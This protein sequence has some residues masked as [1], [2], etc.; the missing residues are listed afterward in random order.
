[1]ETVSVI[2]KSINIPKGA[3]PQTVEIDAEHELRFEAD[4]DQTVII[5]MV[6]GTGEFFGA[7]LAVDRE[8]I[9]SGSKGAIFTWHGCTLEIYGN[10]HFYIA[11]ET[12]MIPYLNLAEAIEDERTRAISS[13]SQGPRVVL[14]GPTDSG[15]SS[16]SRLLMNY[17]SRKG[18]FP[19]F[20][21]LDIGQ[22]SITI[23]AMVAAIQ[24]DQP[25][26]IGQVELS[27][28]PPLVYYYGHVTPSDN[29]KMYK[30]A[31]ANMTKDINRKFD[32]N[33]KA[34]TSGMIINTC[35]WVDGL[36]YELLLYSIDVLNADTVL[37]L[38]HDRLYNDLIQAYRGRRVRVVKLQKSGGVV[39][40]DPSFRRK[41]RMMR[42]KEY[43][44]GIA[45]DLSPHATVLNFRDI[46]IYKVGSS[47]PASQ[48]QPGNISNS[49]PV[50]L[51]E[52][53]PSSEI[54]QAILGVSYASAPDQ[55]LETNIAGFL[56]VTEVNLEKQKMTVLAPSPGNMPSNFFILGSLKWVE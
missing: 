15:K 54:T 26:S 46:H 14:V 13:H 39:A 34:R 28:L 2:P 43:F 12:P 48:N 56:F 33:E 44:Y 20:I 32:L 55:L 45:G 7:E 51:I 52:I 5:K 23:P 53:S 30:L 29:V 9:F 3:T 24:I 11:T 31:I 37:V 6:Q 17:A 50:R 8:Y 10:C 49:D 27:S 36:G 18:H 41:S 21:D 4:F 19:T 42:I 25:V 47:H 22:G 35:G 38:D 40:R 1:M 16:L